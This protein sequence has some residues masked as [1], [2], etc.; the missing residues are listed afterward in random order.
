MREA[1]TGLKTARR[2]PITGAGLGRLAS[3]IRNQNVPL[4]GESFDAAALVWSKAPVIVGAHDTGP[5]IRSQDGFW[6]AISLPIAGSPHAAAGS[7][8]VN[9]NSD[10]GYACGSSFAGRVRACRWRRD[11]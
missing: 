2:T 5:L 11:G 3:A 1:G 8:P 4:S 7:L 10:A 9:G 6:L